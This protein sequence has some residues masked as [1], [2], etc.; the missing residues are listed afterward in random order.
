M[1][2]LFSII[3]MI[4]AMQSCVGKEKDYADIVATLEQEFLE[5]KARHQRHA[6]EFDEWLKEY[7]ESKQKRLEIE[8][9]PHLLKD[10]E[11]SNESSR[12]FRND[13]VLITIGTL[14]AVGAFVWANSGTN[15]SLPVGI[16]HFEVNRPAATL[17]APKVNEAKLAAPAA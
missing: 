8:Q 9:K 4:A 16:R 3:L 1:K 5:M 14:I 7:D 12:L 11:A 10:H 17:V 15:T 13:D 2:K 6:Q